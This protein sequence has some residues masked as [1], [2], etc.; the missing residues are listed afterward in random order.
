[1][2]PEVEPCSRSLIIKR[3]ILLL[4]LLENVNTSTLRDHKLIEFNRDLNDNTTY[5]HMCEYKNVPCMSYDMD[6]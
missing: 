3:I 6:I 2:F 1:M 5:T 4:L